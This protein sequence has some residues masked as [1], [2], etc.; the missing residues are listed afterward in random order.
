[1]SNF[2]KP[3]RLDGAIDDAVREM[4]QVDPRP[5]L[6]HRVAGAIDAGPRQ[7]GGFRASLA[8]AAALTLVVIGWLGVSRSS[9]SVQPVA[10]PQTVTVPSAVPAIPP[11]GPQTVDSSSP[12]AAVSTSRRPT[13]A[14]ESIFGARSPRVSAASVALAAPAGPALEDGDAMVL[15]FSVPGGLPAIP[16]IALAPIRVV[17][18]AIEPL[19]VSALSHRR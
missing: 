18:L 15:P 11:A 7:S 19:T 8:L 10:A 14:P 5:G 17:P 4:M 12:R 2:D 16:P 13:P 3:G 1:M 6:R 9:E